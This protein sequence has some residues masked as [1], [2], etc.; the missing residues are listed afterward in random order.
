M[1]SF[2]LFHGLLF[3]PVILSWAGPSPYLSAGE[4]KD[5]V[6]SP[7]KPAQNGEVCVETGEHKAKSITHI[8]GGI[9]NPAFVKS[10]SNE[11]ISQEVRLI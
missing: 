11:N 8:S 9:P 10:E 2:G 4:S 6:K 5:S 3:L 7:E 1:V